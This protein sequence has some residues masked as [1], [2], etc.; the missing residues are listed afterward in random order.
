MPPPLRRLLWWW[1]LPAAAIPLAITSVLVNR[2][3][4]GVGA[5]ILAFFAAKVMIER[6]RWRY[7]SAARDAEF[8]LCCGC[9]YDMSGCADAGACPECGRAY[10]REESRGVWMSS[11]APV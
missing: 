5:V 3:F 1:L 11:C 8:Q 9:G 2:L 4:W 6:G 7:A 10:V